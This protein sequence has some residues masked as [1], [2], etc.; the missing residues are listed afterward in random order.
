MTVLSMTKL[1]LVL[2]RAQRV[3]CQRLDHRALRN[4]IRLARRNAF[5]FAF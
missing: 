3:I 5:E 1:A 4:T 2:P